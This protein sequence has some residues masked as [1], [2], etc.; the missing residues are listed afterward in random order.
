MRTRLLETN[1]DS[2]EEELA[3]AQTQLTEEREAHAQT[4]AQLQDVTA[5]L[6]QRTQERDRAI[7]E[8]D[9]A[10]ASQKLMNIV[11]TAASAV[12]FAVILL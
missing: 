8:R 12:A 10:R 5:N 2:L 4:R 3:Q 9:S 1:V 6:E 11:A 7:T